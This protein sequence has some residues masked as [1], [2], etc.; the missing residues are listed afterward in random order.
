MNVLLIDETADTPKVILNKEKNIFEM[1]GRSLPEDSVSFF[2]PVLA[3]LQE[4]GSAPNPETLF[5]F[6]LEYFNTASSKL[7]LDILHVLKKIQGIQVLWYYYEDDEDILDIGKEF[8][9][10]VSIPFSFKQMD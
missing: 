3:W 8:S 5:H 6:K 1:S 9:E 7:I 2:S 4:Y 10:Q